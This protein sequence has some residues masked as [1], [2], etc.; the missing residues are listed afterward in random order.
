MKWGMKLRSVAMDTARGLEPSYSVI[1]ACSRS[2]SSANRL[3]GLLSLNLKLF[4]LSFE[5]SALE[6]ST[7]FVKSYEKSPLK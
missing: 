7:K 6:I 3:S 5:M 4:L 2:P 1:T